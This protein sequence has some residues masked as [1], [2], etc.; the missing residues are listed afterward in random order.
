VIY[1]RNA[2]KEDNVLYD[3]PLDWYHKFE[4]SAFS[5]TGLMHGSIL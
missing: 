1:I 4:I 3:I 2:N 5:S